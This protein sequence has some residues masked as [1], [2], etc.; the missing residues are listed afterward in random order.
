VSANRNELTATELKILLDLFRELGHSA[1]N[2]TT[3]AKIRDIVREIEAGMTA[4]RH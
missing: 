1:A 2:L 3:T 4:T